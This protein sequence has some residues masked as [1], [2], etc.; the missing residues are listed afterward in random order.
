MWPFDSWHHKHHGHLSEFEKKELKLQ[1]E[2]VRL[3]R[4][5]LAV[6]RKILKALSPR[7]ASLKIAFSETKKMADPVVGPVVMNV[8]DAVVASV[9]G[10]DQNG[11]VFAGPIPTPSFTID[12][13]TIASLDPATGDV[14]GLAAGVA[15]LA[16]S[17]TTAEGASLSD[18]ETV[19]VVALPP[20]VPILSSIKVAFAPKV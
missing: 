20:P 4:E 3:Q 11:Q 2:Q 6:D 17:L 13:S 12:D 7:L 16:A 8:G 10:F 9:V 5:D 14:V 1:E 15:N 19:T 18:T